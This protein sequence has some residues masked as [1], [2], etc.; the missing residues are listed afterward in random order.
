M[1]LP[2]AGKT[3]EE[4]TTEE[5]SEHGVLGGPLVEKAARMQAE[6]CSPHDPLVSVG[7]MPGDWDISTAMR[8]L[9]S[10]SNDSDSSMRFG[11]CAF[12]SWV[13]PAESWNAEERRGEHIDEWIVAIGDFGLG[14]GLYGVFG[15][16]VWSKEAP[17]D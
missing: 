9:F 5:T 15:F 7:E 4:V 8:H 6:P 1:V 17:L 13:F 3:S 2:H 12:P 16:G 11:D 10:P 14:D